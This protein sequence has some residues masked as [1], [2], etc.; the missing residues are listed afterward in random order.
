MPGGP[1][2]TQG[3]KELQ[4]GVAKRK[5]RRFVLKQARGD[6]TSFQENT[7]LSIKKQR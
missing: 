1:P 4:Q 2:V 6:G 5:S 7:S 3:S